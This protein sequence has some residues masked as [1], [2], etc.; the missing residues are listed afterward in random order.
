[1]KV[2]IQ[3]LYFVFLLCFGVP[4]LNSGSFPALLLDPLNDQGLL[5]GPFSNLDFCSHL[6]QRF[7]KLSAQQN[8]QKS[9]VLVFLCLTYFYCNAK[10]PQSLRPA[11]PNYRILIR[12]L[13][14][15]RSF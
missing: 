10:V 3:L 11:N 1:M 2:L 5:K 8:H 6:G 4:L 12:V 14:V 15:F 9:L 13:T 7:A